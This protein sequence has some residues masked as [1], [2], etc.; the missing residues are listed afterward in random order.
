MVVVADAPGSATW[1]AVGSSKY[2]TVGV[3]SGA[4]QLATSSCLPS[5]SGC[6]QVRQTCAYYVSNVV[7]SQ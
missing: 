5:L 7:R 4:K 6:P 1:A 3:G 2:C